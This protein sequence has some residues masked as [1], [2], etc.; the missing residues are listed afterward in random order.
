MPQ[1]EPL[2]LTSLIYHAAIDRNRKEVLPFR[3]VYESNAKA[4][5]EHNEILQFHAECRAQIASLLVDYQGHFRSRAE[6]VGMYDEYSAIRSRL[7]ALNDLFSSRCVTPYAYRA[8]YKCSHALDIF[9]FTKDSDIFRARL[10][11]ADSIKRQNADIESLRGQVDDLQQSKKI[12]QDQVLGLNIAIKDEQDRSKSLNSELNSVRSILEKCEE[13]NQRLEV[14]NAQLV[15]RFISEK[16]KMASEMNEMNNIVGGFRGFMGGGVS[17]VQGLKNTVIGAVNNPSSSS[18]SISASGEGGGGINDA[19][20]SGS[21]STSYS[22][23]K[24][25]IGERGEAGHTRSFSMDAPARMSHSSS[26]DGDDGFEIIDGKPD[27]SYDEIVPSSSHVAVGGENKRSHSVYSALPSAGRRSSRG[28][29]EEAEGE[30][31]RGSLVTDF[32]PPRCPASIEKIHATD[33]NDVRTES[34]IVVTG[35]ADATVKVTYLGSRDPVFS[36]LGTAP[37][38][39]VDI[40]DD[41]WVLGAS[42]GAMSEVRVWNAINGRQRLSFGGHNNKILCARFIGESRIL[43]IAAALSAQSGRFH[44]LCC[45]C[46]GAN[47]AVTASADRTIKLWDI[48]SASMARP[49]QTI[50]TNSSA[51]SGLLNCPFV[52]ASVSYRS[53][54]IWSMLRTLLYRI[55]YGDCCGV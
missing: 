43:C 24:D 2:S 49:L 13:R 6:A 38:L 41:T 16:E 1:L 20:G 55:F 11:L 34:N 22:K 54:L 48:A 9:R 33:I 50:P 8:Y 32:A 5:R 52:Y 26:D 3:S 46:L 31:G 45:I 42:S 7:S 53:E 51:E 10:E 36:F 25:R 47:R 4:R 21:S 37:V 40:V 29:A 23:E 12:L 27:A 15:S 14:E 19:S 44:P 30:G 28:G 17:F 39:S 35:G 18:S